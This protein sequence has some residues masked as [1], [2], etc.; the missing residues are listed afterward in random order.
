MN[1]GSISQNLIKLQV[2]FNYMDRDPRNAELCQNN[3]FGAYRT[4]LVEDWHDSV[5]NFETAPVH[6]L[7]PAPP[8]PS[9]LTC[10]LKMNFAP[11]AHDFKRYPFP[12]TRK[13]LPTKDGHSHGLVSGFLPPSLTH[14]LSLR[15]KVCRGSPPSPSL[16]PP[17]TLSLPFSF[18]PS[19]TIFVSK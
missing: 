4:G 14:A 10:L 1:G 17:P 3:R 15:I 5:F 12:I 6:I 11:S 18:S 9:P 19:P 7:N 2:V 13:Q 16:P 8:L